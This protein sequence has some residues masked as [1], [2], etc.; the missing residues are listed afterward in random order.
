MGKIRGIHSSP[1]VYTQIT[2]LS[3]AASSMGITTLGLV[4]ET[5]KGPAFEPVLVSNYTEFQNYFGGTSAE[6]F[7][8]SLY[9][10]YELPYIAKS[11]LQASDQLYVCRVLG[12]S[13]YNAGPAFVI[14]ASNSEDS[15]KT[16]YVIA[17]LRARGSYVKYAN[18]GDDC[19][20]IS[21]YDQLQ[22]DCDAID[23]E[24]YTNLSV[25]VN[26]TGVTTETGSTEGYP[27]N[28]ISYGQFTIIAKKDGEEVG[29]YPVSLNLG[30]K[31][32]IYNVLGNNPTEG[33]AALFVEEFYDV[34][35]GDL[36]NRGK[37]NKIDDEVRVFKE[38]QMQA[39]ADPVRDVVE[40]PLQNLTRKQLGQT[41]IYDGRPGESGMSYDYYTITGATISDTTKPME[42]GGIYIVQSK[43]DTTTG[44]KKYVYTA[45][46]DENGEEIKVGYKESGDTVD[47][48]DVVKVLAYDAFVGLGVDNDG[49]TVLVP[50]TNMSDYHDQFRCAT[51]P[52]IVSEL[53][54]DGQDLQVKKL[55]RFHTISDGSDA[56][57]QVKISVSNVR[58]DDGRFDITIRDFNDSDGNI[59]VLESYKN[60]TMVP[61]DP[62]Y[63]GLQIG[64]LD[65]AYESKSKYVMVEVIENDMT[66]TCVPCGFL[67]YP[68]RDYGE[69]QAPT[70]AYNL[71]YEEDIKDKKQYFG[72][73]DLK[74]VDVDMLSYK[75]KNAYTDEYTIGYTNGFHLDSTLND[76]VKEGI[77]LTVTIDGDNSTSGVTWSAV[78]PNN[79]PTNGGSAPRIGSEEEME[80]TIYAN[81]KLRK[82]TVYP[83][84]GFDGWDIYR[85]ARTNGDEFRAD[86]YKGQIING[87]GQTFSKIQDGTALALEGNAITSDYYAYLAGANQFEIPE[88]F[89]INLFATPGI[90]YVNQPK[91]SEEILDMIETKRLDSLY[92]MTTPD[93]PFG[94]SDAVDEMYSSAEAVSN[95]EDSRIDTYYACTYYPWVKYFDTE[96]NI[97]VNL[98]AT[99]DVLRNMANVDNKKFP[100]YAPAG[101]ERGTVECARMHFFA[102]LEDEDNVYDGMINPLKTFSQDGVK[103]W[104]NKTMYSKDTPMNRVNCV[105]LLLYMRK[106]ITE[107]SRV[108]LFEPND[109]TLK[110]EF[111]SIIKPILSQIK[112]D[113]GITDYRLEVSQTPEE[114]DAHEMSAKLWVKPTPTLE[115]LEIDF[116]VTPQGIQFEDM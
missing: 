16:Q 77:G 61:G 40:L 73:S 83:Y 98:P 106:L 113:R 75:G 23:L 50:M 46:V 84:G 22:F 97:Y 6:R 18:V 95:L 82:F 52:W 85:K 96:N 60:L 80:D 65:G 2:D 104:G 86:K 111:E 5:L 101:I 39:V 33:S 20:R 69:L 14:T 56:N 4:G 108:L 55:F 21:K 31:D 90:D 11:Y 49:N 63:I 36:I 57:Q 109:V 74:G 35:L 9:P 24:P 115:Y 32:Y 64:T 102:K 99:K 58:P 29:R 51:T 105:R 43:T 114:M 42:V 71:D 41:F 116:V 7:K 15:A 12:L 100:W 87:Y 30:A 10:K 93:K 26:C 110:A 81:V 48:Q 45:L 1:G 72:L 54:G 79:V 88:K 34:M 17:V 68:V 89:I 47:T 28:A 92:V 76:I 70:F 112:N 78:S 103:V 25:V 91:L 62:K 3:Y 8:D 53:K 13:G 44:A 94:A 38:L 59:V 107:A 67:G 19:N 66:E 27:A 37:I